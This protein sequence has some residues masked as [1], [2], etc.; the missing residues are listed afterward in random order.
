MLAAL[1]KLDSERVEPAL[2]KL[3]KSKDTRFRRWALD[4]LAKME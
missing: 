4:Q 1:K 3:A 2:R